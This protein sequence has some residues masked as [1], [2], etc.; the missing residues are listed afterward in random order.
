MLTAEGFIFYD[1]ASYEY[2][3]S[4]KEKLVE[5][6]LPGNYLSLNTRNYCKVYGEG[7]INFGNNFGQVNVGAYG[8]STYLFRE[9]SSLFN[10]I[11]FFDFFFN[12]NAMEAMEKNFSI[13]QG[14]T[15]VDYSRPVFEKGMR[16][17]LG[18][19]EADKLISQLN[20]YGSYK[21][22][23]DELKKT[24]FLTDVKMAW[25]KNT[26]SFRSVGQIG[27]GNINKSQIN[28]MVDGQIEIIKKRGGDIIN[29]Y[30]ALDDNVWY[31]FNY[32]RGTML[33][34]SS[35]ED[36]NNALK[37]L[38]PDKRNKEVKG[39][40]DYY[41]NLCLPSKKTQFLRK[42]AEPEEEEE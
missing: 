39:L 25:N 30:L 27:V 3:I 41:F 6:S 14:L 13:F 32:N 20:L 15:A 36:F 16:E 37:D 17:M 4:N 22:L 24:F 33:A 42:N 21:K 1:K 29:I 8:N 19:T 23:P 34:V 38:K 5:Q 26:N 7:S 18:K 2:R 11:M 28:K 9:D 12:D 10:M 31:Y 35:N 40:P